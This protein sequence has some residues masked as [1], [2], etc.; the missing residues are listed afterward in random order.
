LSFRVSVLVL[1]CFGGF[2]EVWEGVGAVYLDTAI[3]LVR[4]GYCLEDDARYDSEPVEAAFESEEKVGLAGIDFADAA[5]WKDEVEC[6]D[7]IA[8]ET[9]LVG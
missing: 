1:E 8:R 5:I 7:S 3:D 2:D 4:L 9:V 6:F